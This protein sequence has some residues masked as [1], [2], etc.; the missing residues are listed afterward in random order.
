MCAAPGRRA[1]WG[2]RSGAM[3]GRQLMSSGWQC[4]SSMQRQGQ[5]QGRPGQQPARRCHQQGVYA[6]WGCELL[7]AAPRTPLPCPRG[8]TGL[9]SW[10]ACGL[11]PELRGRVTI[12]AARPPISREHKLAHKADPR[13]G[14]TT[15]SPCMSPSYQGG[16]VRRSAADRRPP[17]LPHGI[18]AI[19]PPD[20][21][22][23]RPRRVIAQQ[24]EAAVIG[25][26]VTAERSGGPTRRPRCRL[27]GIWRR[28]WSASGAAG[29]PAC[30]RGRQRPSPT[31]AR[32]A[33]KTSSSA[34]QLQ[35][36]WRRWCSSSAAAATQMR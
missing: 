35:G 27:I 31:C 6:V 17:L 32:A 30:V 15:S 33:A 36:L 8:L 25:H 22:S 28:W 23:R 4:S 34:L 9:G 13:T 10:A 16:P 29:T 26:D 3:A 11:W 24:T 18:S 5:A 20:A 14:G 19:Q 7:R 12:P 1:S 21:P 2:C